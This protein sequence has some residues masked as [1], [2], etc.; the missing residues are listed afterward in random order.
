MDAEKNI[1]AAIEEKIPGIVEKLKNDNR[2]YWRTDDF[3]PKFGESF[4]D[5][6]RWDDGVKTDEPIG[7]LSCS[8]N[9]DA[10]LSYSGRYMFA[11]AGEFSGY[12]EDDDEVIVRGHGVLAAFD[13]RTG[14]VI[15]VNPEAVWP[16]WGY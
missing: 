15:Y 3:C 4:E 12:G 16:S 7:G 14:Q 9:F 5:S 8:D 11:I 1:I 2:F 6:T 10:N 13:M